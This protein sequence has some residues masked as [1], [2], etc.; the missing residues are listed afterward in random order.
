MQAAI[1]R[2]IRSFTFKH[3]VSLAE[4]MPD[5]PSIRTDEEATELATRLLDNYKGQLARR[6]SKPD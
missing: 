6:S 5:G 2:A 4:P 1:D 3:P